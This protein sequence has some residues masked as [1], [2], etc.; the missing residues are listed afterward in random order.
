MP[1]LRVALPHG[2]GPAPTGSIVDVFATLLGPLPRPPLP[3]DATPEAIL[4]AVLEAQS[5]AGLEPLIDGGWPL[6]GLDAVAAWQATQAR[7]TSLVKAVVVGPY[8]GTA[9]AAEVRGTLVA[10]ADAGCAWIEI[11]EPAAVGIGT[12]PV[13]RQ[14]FADLHRALTADV[15][16]H[17]GLH[18][19]LAVTGGSA[20][21]AGIATVLAGAYASL[22]VDLIDGPDNWRLVAATPADRGIVCGAL[23]TRADSDDSPEL[24]LYAAGYAASTA[25]R[26]PA[27]V[28]LATARSLQALPWELAVRKLERLGSAARLADASADER[29]ASLDP[30]SVDIRSAAL[31]T[32][33]PRGPGSRKPPPRGGSRPA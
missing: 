8:S 20:D 5:G 6:P 10:L 1:A 29:R 23:G 28:G 32:R 3:E 15:A 11:H 24:L 27:R 25:G 7:T 17:P 18:L 16:G 22:A 33:Q 9:T 30:R 19:S 13:E 26:G 12:D 21:A 2:W 14:R 4:E 31:G